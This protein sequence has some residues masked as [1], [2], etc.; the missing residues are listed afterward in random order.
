MGRS[1]GGESA[2]YRIV[3]LIENTGG[4]TAFIGTPTT[5]VLGEDD[6]SWDVVV[7]ADNTNDALVIQATGGS[8]DE[9]R[10]VATVRTAEVN[11]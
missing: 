9:V 4:N 5:T 11:W 10:W 2:G 6:A 8:G 7:I 3:G 1:S